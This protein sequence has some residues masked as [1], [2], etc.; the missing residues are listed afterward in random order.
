MKREVIN[1][2]NQGSNLIIS[3]RE[4]SHREL[5]EIKEVLHLCDGF[6]REELTHTICEHLHWVTA[7][8]RHKLTACSKLLE[9]L[10]DS[11]QIQLPPK[12]K[13]KSPCK[14]DFLNTN[15]T[16]PKKEIACSFAHVGPI[17]LRIASQKKD[18]DLWN[19][20]INRYHY[21]GYK[22]PF[23]CRLRYFI[24]SNHGKLGCI[25]LAGAAKSL[26]SRDKW[27]G[28]KDEVRLRNLPWIVNNT[29]YLIFP[30]VQVKHLASHTLGMLARRVRDDW[31]QHFGYRPML[32][33][34]F[35]DPAHY[36]GTCYRAAGWEH[37][38]DTTGRGLRR[39]GKEYKTT[40]K[41]IFVKP[42]EKRCQEQ[43]C[44]EL[45]GREDI[46]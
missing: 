16:D 14:K 12:K 29:R 39:Q 25:L 24:E 19:E 5:S 9:Q 30:W 21:L 43:L 33:E 45:K 13:Q 6:S 34:T 32:M 35:V 4:I 10:D 46:E 42:L 44:M 1:M 11:N 23:G 38:G 3:G 20:Y 7:T 36:Q 8:G 37:L 40:P 26:K 27:I 31:F 22:K 2:N 18:K 28:W 17:T 41:M 15:Q